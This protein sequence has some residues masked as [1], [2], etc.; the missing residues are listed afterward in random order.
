MSDRQLYVP[1]TVTR[2]VLQPTQAVLSVCSTLATANTTVSTVGCRKPADP[3]QTGCRKASTCGFPNC[4]S[5]A[6]S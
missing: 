4:D 1:P 2:V 3:S 6:Q 5:G